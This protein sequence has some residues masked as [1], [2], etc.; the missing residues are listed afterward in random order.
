MLLWLQAAHQ[1]PPIYV[2][3]QQPPVPPGLPEWVKLL[4]SAGVGAL[5]GISANIAMEF[6]KPAIA[7]RLMRKTVERQVLFGEFKENLNKID[8][9]SRMAKRAENGSEDNH[10]A[11]LSYIR[12]TTSEISTDLLR[13]CYESQR[14]IL[15]EMDPA[16]KL[17][18]FYARIEQAKEASYKLD[19]HMAN[20][21]LSLAT[22]E[23]KEIIKNHAIEYLAPGSPWDEYFDP[24]FD[25]NFKPANIKPDV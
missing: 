21:Y 3:V 19:F 8:A 4:I 7:K 10:A 14:A 11:C 22:A 16:R 23:G 20:V 13:S 6:I 17:G 25:P 12:S 24:R 9:V 18:S 2:T 5:F 1:L 15:D